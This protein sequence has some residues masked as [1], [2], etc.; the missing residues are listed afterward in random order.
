[1]YVNHQEA[2]CHC[3]V[4]MWPCTAFAQGHSVLGE[5]QRYMS[6]ILFDSMLS[7]G[8]TSHEEPSGDLIPHELASPCNS[9]LQLQKQDHKTTHTSSSRAKLIK[10]RT[11]THIPKSLQNS[12]A[13]YRRV[14]PAWRKGWYLQT[15]RWGMQSLQ[16][17]W[18]GLWQHLIEWYI[19]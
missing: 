8:N 4:F 1:M 2:Q 19:Y 14:S 6:S 5:Q 15:G 9:S 11:V 17:Q 10:Q 18:K 16:P 13:K 12:F 3:W 7:E